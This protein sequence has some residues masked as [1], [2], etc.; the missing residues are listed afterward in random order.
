MNS[1]P[2]G[3]TPTG[4]GGGG[5]CED[6]ILIRHEEANNAVSGTFTA[7]SWQTRP[8]NTEVKDDGGH[9]SLS[10]N[11]ITVA[12]GVYRFRAR[13]SAY[14]VDSHKC[15][16]QNVTDAITI[17]IGSNELAS[18]ALSAHTA[19]TVEGEFTLASPKILE[20]Q[21]YCQTTQLS[22]GFGLRSNFGVIEVYAAI[23]FWRKIDG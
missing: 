22:L 23:E 3:A 6:Y 2:V 13:G 19:S 20:L 16:L 10:S 9:V 15:R 1:N 7:G 17:E 21:H 12:A 4:G 5:G 18:N 11:Q 8:L 14:K